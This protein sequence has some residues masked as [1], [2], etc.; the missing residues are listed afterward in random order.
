MDDYKNIIYEY[1]A[2][3]E[4]FQDRD[5]DKGKDLIPINP[6]ACVHGQCSNFV[7]S[8]RRYSPSGRL[9][10]IKKPTPKSQSQRSSFKSPNFSHVQPKVDSNQFPGEQIGFTPR[11][12]QE[13]I[14]FPDVST[15]GYG[16]SSAKTSFVAKL[17]SSSKED[18]KGPFHVNQFLYT[19]SYNATRKRSTTMDLINL[20][21]KKNKPPKKKI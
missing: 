2:R 19:R 21:K 3:Y 1:I 8:L 16:S 6:F 18:Q 10:S 20:L 13:N 5:S 7:G 17:D 9:E 14:R 11:K 15:G 12:R 4:V